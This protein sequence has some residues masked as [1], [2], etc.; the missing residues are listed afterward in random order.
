LNY[1]DNI[2]TNEIALASVYL[3][4]RSGNDNLYVGGTINPLNRRLRVHK[5]RAKYLSKNKLKMSKKDIWLLDALNN[6][7]NI[8][9]VEIDRVLKSEF[10]FW[11]KHYISLFKTFGFTLMNGNSG[12]CVFQKRAFTEEQKEAS[13]VGKRKAVLEYDKNGNVI[14]RFDSVVSASKSTGIGY[15]NLLSVLLGKT[16]LCSKRFFSYESTDITVDEV[17]NAFNAKNRDKEKPVLQFDIKGNFVAE[18][19]S[20]EATPFKS[21]TQKSAIAKA[22][23]GECKTKY[24]YIWKYKNQ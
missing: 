4:S 2:H 15:G 19:K 20:V 10:S 21:R 12:G 7:E 5:S 9:I 17:V 22:C 1:V 18:Y 13:A 16:K 23:R 8:E 24:G 3:L 6:K 14:S 11:E